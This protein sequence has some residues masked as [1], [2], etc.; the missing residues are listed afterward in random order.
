MKK[1]VAR[2][3]Q[4]YREKSQRRTR[5]RFLLF[6]SCLM[7]AMLSWLLNILGKPYRFE[8]QI[9]IVFENVPE[10]KAL[11][12]THS[13]QVLCTIEGSGWFFLRAQLDFMQKPLRVDLRKFEGLREINLEEN[14]ETLNK[15]VVGNARIIDVSPR[16]LKYS[17]EEAGRKKV[18]VR[19]LLH[20]SFE[21]EYALSDRIQIIPDSIFISGPK[22]SLK[23]IRNI[24]TEAF[25][26]EYL[27]T[28]KKLSLP[29]KNTHKNVVMSQEQVE[30]EISVDKYTED[31]K[32]L[33]L[34]VKGYLG[35]D[36]IRLFP[37]VCTLYYQ[38]GLGNFD[39]VQ[40]LK[41]IAVRD[42]FDSERLMVRLADTPDYIRYP[43][44]Y[45]DKVEYLM[46]K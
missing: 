4:Y 37:S 33:P 22:S 45:P 46:L 1:R 2:V 32:V 7:I 17:F 35:N 43:R 23:N 12:T 21:E 44:I 5:R 9:P 10:Y 29:L 42:P 20:V 28:N 11:I 13:H 27:S 24:E 14:I 34:Q 39:K 6:F 26:T 19:L 3:F 36:P 38:V 16:I 30:V 15:Q 41:L 18:P 25:E 40:G 31:F 8:V